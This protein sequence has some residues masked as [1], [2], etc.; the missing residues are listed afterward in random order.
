DAGDN[1]GLGFWTHQLQAATAW[2]PLEHQA[3]AV[4]LGMTYEWHHDKKGTDIHPGSHFSLNWGISQFLPLNK[5]QTWL[6]ELG[7]LGYDQWQITGDRGSDVSPFFAGAKDEVHAAGLEIGLVHT[8]SNVAFLVHYLREFHA[9]DRFEGEF[10]TATL[11][12]GF[13]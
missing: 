12:F 5:D 4:T 1:I 2:Y 8:K 11:V 13:P 3:T 6:A 10:F 9:R 7:V